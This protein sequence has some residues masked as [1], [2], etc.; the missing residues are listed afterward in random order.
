[1]YLKDEI[2]GFVPTPQANDIIKE[3]TQGSSI[4]RM[5]RIESMTSETK[6]FNVMTDGAGA[7]W[8]GEGKR[9]QT[10]KATWIPR[11]H[12]EKACCHYSHNKGKA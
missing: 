7:H 1:M 3:V 8:V 2:S 6:K 12:S 4:L 9:I 10:S 5:S 11:N